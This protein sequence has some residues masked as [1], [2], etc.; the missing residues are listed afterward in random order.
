[1]GAWSCREKILS[2]AWYNVIV[3]GTEL[4]GLIY[5]ALA[6]RHGYRVGVVGN[7]ARQNTYRHE[8][9]VF[10][11]EPERYYGFTT[12]PVMDRVMRDLGLSMEIKNRPKLVDPMLQVVTADMRLDVVG[13]SG[14]WQRELEREMPRLAEKLRSFEDWAAAETQASDEI[15]LSDMLFPLDGMRGQSKYELAIEASECL[16]QELQGRVPGPIA[17]IHHHDVFS[18]VVGG[19]LSHLVNVSPHPA[20]SLSIARLWTHLRAGIYRLPNGLDGFKG[21]FLRKLKDQ[22]GDY[23]AGTEVES[24]VFK[25][26]KAREVVL[27]DRGETL[28]CDLL[29]ANLEPRELATIIPL[30]KQLGSYHEEIDALD[31]AGWRMV[32]NIAL[33]PRVI[34]V[35]MGPEV[36]LINEMDQPFE[37]ANCLWVSRPG[38]GPFERRE[39]RP[40]PGVLTVTAILPARQGTPQVE[41]VQRLMTE[42]RSHLRALIPWFDDHVYA[43]DT[44]CLY[45]DPT[46][47]QTMLDRKCLT[48]IRKTPYSGM[49]G[50][51][52]LPPTTPY[53]NIFLCCDSLFSGLGLEGA[54]L[55]ALQTLEH[56]RKMLKIRSTLG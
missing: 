44:P 52:T 10:L 47:G 22:C 29:V 40:G 36:V 54:F 26:G 46:T 3:V 9:N 17:S 13:H 15:L 4:T 50:I 37:G 11:H 31:V 34:P 30:K 41:H 53:K 38:A 49:L 48:S 39:G 14:H 51:G 23:H 35:G 42:I 27:T 28:G 20:S 7:Q 5:A 6:A 8:G 55:G 12:S 24:I 43:M 19:P 21:M 2:S 33:D 1:M 45:Q 32:M 16:A 25:R 56:T 18:A